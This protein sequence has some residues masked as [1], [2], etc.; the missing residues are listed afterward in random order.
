LSTLY[1]VFVVFAG[2][3]DDAPGAG[4]GAGAGGGATGRIATL[5]TSV[6]GGLYGVNSPQCY[7][8]HA[9]IFFF[10]KQDRRKYLLSLPPPSV[11][12]VA[13]RTRHTVA[14][15]TFPLCVLH[16]YNGSVFPKHT[17]LNIGIGRRPSAS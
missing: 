3:G 4:A 15:C 11:A 14:I 1:F 2:N 13:V 17:P 10:L 6:R 12:A 7:H 9:L 8:R 5:A 16:K